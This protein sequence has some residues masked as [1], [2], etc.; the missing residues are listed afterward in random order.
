[1]SDTLPTPSERAEIEAERS[2]A[3]RAVYEAAVP[4]EFRTASIVDL[5]MIDQNRLTVRKW[6]DGTQPTLLIFG[7]R[8][9]GKTHAGYAVLNDAAAT[10]ARV[11]GTTVAEL[12]E[13]LHPDFP[14]HSPAGRLALDADLFLFDDLKTRNVA[15]WGVDELTGILDHRAREGKRQIITTSESPADLVAFYGPQAWA[16]MSA[17]ALI[18]NFTGNRP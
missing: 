15:R 13:T 4:D 2:A 18:L 5:R 12:I 8:L 16:L 1:M 14:G 9:T 3:R 6:A 17:G 11:Y 7:G 10:G